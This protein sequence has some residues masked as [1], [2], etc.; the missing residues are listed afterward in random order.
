MIIGSVMLGLALLIVVVLFL[1][2]PLLI[3]QPASSSSETWRRQLEQQKE[4]LLTQIRGLDFDH[5]TGK[6]PTDVYELQRAQLMSQAA[7]V[8]Q[9]LDEMD[10]GSEEQLRQQI[11]AAVAQRR[12]Q[13]IPASNGQGSYCSNCGLHLDLGDKFCARCGQAVRTVQPTF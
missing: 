9:S 4:S 3:V 7:A 6:I 10:A 12:H 13:A 8:L 11:E 5:D 2:R 1:A